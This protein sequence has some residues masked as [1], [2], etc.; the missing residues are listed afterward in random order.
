MAEINEAKGN[1][2]DRSFI[3]IIVFHFLCVIIFIARYF[4]RC[5]FIS[6]FYTSRIIAPTVISSGIWLCSTISFPAFP[7]Y[8]LALNLSLLFLTFPNNLEICSFVL[9]PINFQ[10]GEDSCSD[11]LYFAF[12]TPF[13]FFL[14]DKP[15]ITNF[16]GVSLFYFQ[17]RM[18]LHH[19]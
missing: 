9:L 16:L 1:V 14:F 7:L 18:N 8:L 13:S 6:Y 12:E 4:Y 3:D 11:F 19:G 17:L 15:K 10:T 2:A 5:F